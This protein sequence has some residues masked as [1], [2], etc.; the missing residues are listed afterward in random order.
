MSPYYLHASEG[1]GSLITTVQLKGENYEDWSRHV[2]NALRTKRKL[3]FI[4]GTLKKPSTPVEIEQ[5]EVVN[6]MLVACIMNTIEPT[7]RTTISMV[8][9]AQILW[10]DLKLQFSVGNGA[11]IHELKVDISCCKHQGD[12]V[13]VYYG[14]LKKMWDELDVYKPIRTCSC[15]ELAALLQQDQDED[16]TH[17]FLAG[18]DNSRFGTVRSTI[19][20]IEPLP[21]LSQVYQRII[22]EERQQMI[23][24]NSD[25]K[26]DVVGFSA[27]AGS[28][29][30][31]WGNNREGQV[32]CTYCGK[33][34]HDVSECHQVKGYPEWWGVRGHNGG[35]R[36][37]ARGRGRGGGMVGAFGRGRGNYSREHITGNSREQAI[38]NSA[39]VISSAVTS[40]NITRREGDYDR[41]SLPQLN[42]EQ[43]SALLAF[44]NT[45]KHEQAEKLSGKV[46][47]IDFII[48]TGASH[49]M[50]WNLNYL[51]NVVDIVPCSIGLP[52]G[53]CAI[54]L[55]QGDLWLGGDVFLRAV[56]YAP[57]LKCCLISVAKLLKAIE[58]SSITFT[59]DLCFAGPYQDDSDWR[60]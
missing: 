32:N 59:A 10:E 11:R 21:K 40:A 12:S 7:V 38:A 47:P 8:D 33:P 2:R 46:E 54:A 5:W 13:M 16:R 48:D 25:A 39:Q 43:W 52:D 9:D 49:Y 17:E 55:K 20:S 53:D 22:R 56:L 60:G 19:T 28:R 34:G 26:I 36:G 58:G 37:S 35:A 42:D 50:T 41:A 27:Q 1:P 44:L 45:P 15:G 30:R 4:D 23:A 14:R 29:V 18:L 57:S 3:G 6:S 24:R 51:I 31:M